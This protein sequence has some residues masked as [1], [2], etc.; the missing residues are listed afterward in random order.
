MPTPP[1]SQF[2]DQFAPAAPAYATFRPRY[3]AALFAALVAYAPARHL[4]WDCATGSGQ[5][6]I[7]LADHFEQV[8]ATDASEAQLAAA[9]PHP[10]VRYQRASAE[11]SGLPPRSV[12]LVTVAQAL[13]WLDRPAFY[14]EVKRVL[15]PDGVIAVWTYGLIEIGPDVDELIRTFYDRTVGPYWPPERALVETGYRTIDFPF[16]ELHLPTVHMEAALTLEQLGGYLGTWSAVLRYRAA[17]GR[18]PVP[19]LLELLRTR[20]GG[21]AR[22]RTV[23]WPLASRVGRVTGGADRTGAA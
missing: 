6:A 10:R 16:A 5:A 17:Q 9:L 23:R 20:W 13:H 4:A 2:R 21:P 8:V 1:S 15:V 11:A 18:D 22:A 12:A 14:A 3:P 19:E 7:G